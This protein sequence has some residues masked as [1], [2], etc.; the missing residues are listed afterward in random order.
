PANAKKLRTT[1]APY[2]AAGRKQTNTRSGRA[3]E[4]GPGNVPGRALGR[5]PGRVLGCVPGLG[6]PLHRQRAA[7]AARAGYGCVVPGGLN[8]PPLHGTR[9]G[10]G[11]R[12]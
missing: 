6:R 10:L 4:R 7:R 11:G 2:V 1:L 3:L 12:R 5:F 9:A 8:R